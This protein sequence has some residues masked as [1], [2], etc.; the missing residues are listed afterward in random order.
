[1]TLTIYKETVWR[2]RLTVRDVDGV[3]YALTS[4]TLDVI[5][6]KRSTSTALITLAPGSG[7]TLL[8]QGTNPG[9]AD[10]EITPA[11]TAALEPGAYVIAVGATTGGK[12]TLAVTPQRLFLQDTPG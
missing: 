10:I 5:V 11:Q 6:S 9:Q 1:M 4:T 7:I 3:P 12:R 2:R 8:D